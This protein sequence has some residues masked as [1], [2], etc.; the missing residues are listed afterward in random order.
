MGRPGSTSGGWRVAHRAL[1]V[2]SKGKRPL[3]KPM[4]GRKDNT[5]K[6]S[7]NRGGGL[8]W[9]RIVIGGWRL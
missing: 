4:H 2:K 8:I 5:K 1:V 6:L 3:A 7:S 9:L